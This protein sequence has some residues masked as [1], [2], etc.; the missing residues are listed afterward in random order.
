MAA[1]KKV[2]RTTK[3]AKKKS[4][5]E[6]KVRKFCPMCGSTRIGRT[7]TGYACSQCTSRFPR[8]ATEKVKLKKRPS[9]IR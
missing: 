9:Y 6:G 3:V 4:G 2:K 7:R 5:T 8:P 1:K